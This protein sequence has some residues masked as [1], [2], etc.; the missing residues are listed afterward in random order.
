MLTFRS[1]VFASIDASWSRPSYWP[2]WGGLTFEMVTERGA[3]IVDAFKQ[4]VTVYSHHLERPSWHFWGSDINQ[5]MVAEFIAAIR[6][7]RPPL[8]TGA[9]GYRAVEAT[10]AAYE[11]ARRGQPVQIA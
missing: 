9:D 2:T 10:I 5:A 3:V 7:Q 6:Q 8:V 11:S 1:G 4:N